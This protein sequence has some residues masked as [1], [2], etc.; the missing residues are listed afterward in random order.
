MTRINNIIW[1]KDSITAW[2]TINEMFLGH[3]YELGA[4]VHA[5]ALYVYDYTIGIRNPKLD[6]EFDFGRHFNYTM[7]KWKSLVSNYIDRAELD[8]IKEE[9]K[10]EETKSRSR[11]YNLALQFTNKHGHG[12]NCLLSMVF[13]RRAN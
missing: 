13:S 1:F 9:V 10:A 12:K 11:I 4:T 5:H 8:S 6:P 3:D 7:S 2:E